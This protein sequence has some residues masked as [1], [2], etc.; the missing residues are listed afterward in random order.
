ML[1]RGIA[2]CRDPLGGLPQVVA[3]ES[4]GQEAARNGAW[5]TV[6]PERP[7]QEVGRGTALSANFCW[8]ERPRIWVGCSV[9]DRL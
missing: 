6:L 9:H 1:E 5:R 8:E 7:K 3:A 4:R 2:N